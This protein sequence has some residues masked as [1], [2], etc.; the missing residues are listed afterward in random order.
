MSLG[1]HVLIPPT[2]PC[3]AVTVQAILTS[4]NGQLSLG[5]VPS[6]QCN[7]NGNIKVNG[8]VFH[9]RLKQSFVQG[10]FDLSTFFL[11]LGHPKMDLNT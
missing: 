1:S 7:G 3:N 4:I 2:Q 6:A 11:K 9:K 10:N 5:Q 8:I